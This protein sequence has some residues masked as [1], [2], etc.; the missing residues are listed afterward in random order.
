MDLQRDELR[1]QLREVDAANRAVLPRWRSALHQML[2]PES[3]LRH[4][5]KAAALGVPSP[6]RRSF[7]RV[8]GVTV[9][10]AA[11]LAACGDDDGGGTAETGRAPTTTA[12]G[13][14]GAPVDLDLTLARTAASIENL[15]VVTYQTAIDSGV[16]TTAA[17]ADAAALFRDHHQAHADAIN[18]VVTGAGAM[19]VTDPNQVLFDAAVRPVL[20]AGPDE[21]S[22]VALAYELESTAVQAYAFAG[23]NLS[24]PELRSTIM[25]I[26]GVEARHAAILKVLAQ[27][28]PPSAVFE[29]GA[30]VAAADPGIPDE[31]LVS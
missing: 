24:T 1:R 18:A 12:P 13:T 21:A 5:H 25:T 6:G 3:G 19:A 8:G 16:V 7:L 22:I 15:A 2:S 23:G 26:G 9:L 11:V 14:T 17:V 29:D 28:A 4:D 27:A 31:A 30:F 20:D 10:G